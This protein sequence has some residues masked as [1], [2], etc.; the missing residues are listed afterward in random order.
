MPAGTRLV[1][2]LV[3]AAAL[4]CA[5]PAPRGPAAELAGGESRASGPQRTLVIAVRNEPRAIAALAPKGG[6]AAPSFS[7]RP[8]NA[9]LDLVDDRGVGRPYLAQSL[10]E[11]N[12][13]SWKVFPNGRMETSYRLK[14]GLTWHDG[15]PLTT[16]DFRFAWT[17]YNS[18][19]LGLAGGLP[20]NQVDEVSAPDPHSLVIRWKRP[21]PGAGVLQVGTTNPGLVPL[22]RHLLAATFVGA[23]PDAIVDHPY[24]TEDFVGLGP[25]RLD[26]WEFGSFIEA[27][28][29]EGHALGRPRIDRV[30]LSF[31]SDANA[32]LANMRAGAVHL[33]TDNSLAFHQGLELKQEWAANQGGTFL[34][35]TGAWRSVGPQFRP[36]IVNPRALLDVRVR[37]ALAHS[38]DRDSLNQGLW[39]GEG[40]MTETFVAPTVDYY[41]SVERAIVKYPYDL[42][43]SERLMNEA[44]YT[45]GADGFHASPPEGRLTIDLKSTA[46]GD[47]DT[48][49]AILAAGWRQAGF[50]VGESSVSAA[51]SQDGQTRSTYP[52]LFSF[53]QNAAEANVIASFS[54]TQIPRPENRWNGTNRG[55]WSS[56]ANDRLLEAFNTTLEP[57]ERT[58]Q[59]VQLARMLSEELP[60]LPLYFQLTPGPFVSALRGPV[61][62]SAALTTGALSWNIHE[63]KWVF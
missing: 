44:G 56:P 17:I 41:P 39:A 45:R 53:S 12:T 38:I 19:D 31:F 52:A 30:R 15:G 61:P 23:S 54:T 5:P 34:H 33:A 63:W 47:G 42:R 25:Y 48:E 51:L 21:Y 29:F 8:F 58:R 6:G 27:V 4:G 49:R 7:V 32:A 9:Y 13:D 28:A 14:P 57:A 50:D 20:L 36:D 60:V 26:R 62:V 46:G 18:P 59:R 55:G 22:P 10:P 16:E 37:R 3:L 11:L 35:T 24:W 40:I 43:A 2:L 1:A